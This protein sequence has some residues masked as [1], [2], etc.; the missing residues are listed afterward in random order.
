MPL[1]SPSWSSPVDAHDF[2]CVR[3]SVHYVHMYVFSIQ[4][5]LNGC[6]AITDQGIVWLARTF[7]SLTEVSLWPY[8]QFYVSGL[9]SAFGCAIISCLDIITSDFWSYRS[10]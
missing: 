3:L 7:P 4:V 6:F 2:G 9:V 1:S 5:H 8:R 10:S